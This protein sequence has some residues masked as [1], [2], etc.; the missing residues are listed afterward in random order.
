MSSTWTTW[1]VR[2]FALSLFLSL[3]ANFTPFNRNV[4]ALIIIGA[5]LIVVVRGSHKAKLV[6]RFIMDILDR[7]TNKRALEE[8]I[9]KNQQQTL[10]IDADAL[11]SHVKS[12]VIGQDEVADEVAA[13]IRRRIA[14]RRKDK[15]IAVFC[16]AGPPGVGKTYFSKVL[17]ERLYGDEAQLAFFDMSQYSQPHAAASLF[18][19]AKGY[20]GSDTFGGLT[21]ALRDRPACVVL[22]DEFEKAHPEVMKR[23]LTAWNDGFVTEA[24]T[25]KKISTNEAIFILTTNAAASRMGEVWEQHKDDHDERARVTRVLLE[26][27]SFPPEVLSRIDMIFNFKPLVGLDVAR[28][29]GLEIEKLVDQFGLALAEGGIDA[30]I[31]FEALRRQDVLGTSGVREIARAMERE[32]ADSLIDA[33][34]AGAELISLEYHDGAIRAIAHAHDNDGSAPSAPA[35]AQET[36]S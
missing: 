7:L 35:N 21:A 10:V 34:Q 17:C 15:P 36:E 1:M 8:K 23:F 14:G 9:E 18:G 30:D 12:K 29:V 3:G 19:Q 25:G 20:V 31:L 26:E 13:Q 4:T 22:L 32:I 6:P 28:V 5:A 2:F 27:A 16:F 33:K 24:S 11:A